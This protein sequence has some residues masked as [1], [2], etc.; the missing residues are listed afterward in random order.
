VE[1]DAPQQARSPSGLAGLR[2]GQEGQR[3][4]KTKDKTK[5]EKQEDKNKTKTK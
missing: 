1:G 5:R 3:R 4:G 2:S